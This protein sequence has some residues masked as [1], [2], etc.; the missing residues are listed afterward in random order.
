MSRPA[1]HVHVTSRPTGSRPRHVTSSCSRAR[2]VTSSCSRPRH[3]TSSC[4]HPRQVTSSCSRPRHVTS[5]CSR[6]HHV[7]SSCSR[8]RHAQLFYVQLF[9]V[10]VNRPSRDLQLHTMRVF[11]S[12]F[13]RR[14]RSRHVVVFIS[15]SDIDLQDNEAGETRWQMNCY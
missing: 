14:T 13:T 9:H 1:V 12:L 15:Q 11:T 7:T 6:P 10:H 2:H 8:P 4:S 3:V 5:S